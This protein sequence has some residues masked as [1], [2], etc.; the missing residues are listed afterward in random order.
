MKAWHLNSQNIKREH[1]RNVISCYEILDK[2][3]GVSCWNKTACKEDFC[4]HVQFV[5]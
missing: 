5:I 2:F 4:H 3:Y 1:Y